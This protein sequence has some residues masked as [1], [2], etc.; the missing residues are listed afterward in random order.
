MLFHFTYCGSVLLKVYSTVI[1]LI[2]NYF[3]YSV[4]NKH[5]CR[6]QVLVA[7]HKKLEA[8]LTYLRPKHH[9]TQHLSDL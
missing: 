4:R 3:D 6:L 7:G 1:I 8:K 2:G 9:S 5:F